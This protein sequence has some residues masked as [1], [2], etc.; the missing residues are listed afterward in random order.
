[1]NPPRAVGLLTRRLNIVALVLSLVA[2]VLAVY[3]DL[4]AQAYFRCQAR[5]DEVL[6][7]RTR[8]LADVGAQERT[9][10]RDRDDALDAVFLDVSFA[11]PPAERTA[12]DRARIAAKF[13]RYLRAAKTVAD[14]RV[15]A[16][17]ARAD[18]PTPSAPSKVCG[19]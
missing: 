14:E 5:V 17:K 15:K 9:A 13:A 11:K 4:Q 1:V 7:E 2:L 6:I 3:K 10:Q 18:N 16:D 8:I 12:E 19:T